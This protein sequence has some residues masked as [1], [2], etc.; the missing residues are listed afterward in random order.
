MSNLPLG[1]TKRSGFEI[2]RD[3]LQICREPSSYSK[4]WRHSGQEYPRFMAFLKDLKSLELL[5]ETEQRIL[6][7]T[8]RGLEYISAIDTALS[9]LVK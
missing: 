9:Y 5:E 7:T 1:R 6:I 2:M 8:A 4:V 3:I